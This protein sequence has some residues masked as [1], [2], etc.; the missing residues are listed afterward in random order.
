MDGINRFIELFDKRFSDKTVSYIWN[1]VVK[2]GASGRNQNHPQDHI[3][4]IELENF[5]VLERELEILK[6]DIILFVS[7]PNYDSNIEKTLQTIEFNTFNS[8]FT[9]RQLAKLKFKHFDN[10]YRTY[11]PNYL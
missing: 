6:P 5:N 4:N 7:G 3:Y 9:K 8:S 10:I 11:H 2:I 1:N